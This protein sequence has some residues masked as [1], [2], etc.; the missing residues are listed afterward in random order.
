MKLLVRSQFLLFFIIPFVGYGQSKPQLSKA[1]H[2]SQYERAGY[3]HMIIDKQNIY[4]VVF[5]E[6]PDLR[7]PTYIYYSKSLDEGK[8]WSKPLNL[9][10]DGSGNGSGHPRLIL[11]KDGTLYAIW[12]RYGITGSAY[13]IREVG[14]DGRGGN[15]QGT[16]FAKTLYQGVWSSAFQ[17]SDAQGSQFSWFPTLHPNGKV[18]L[19]WSEVSPE[20]LKNNWLM[21]YYADWIRVASIGRT[22]VAERNTYSPY[23][24]ANYAGGPPKQMGAFNLDG[25]VAKDGALRLIFER[26]D[27]KKRCMWYFD[28]KK[29]EI[30]YT[31]PLYKEGN[32]FQNPARLLYDEKGLDHIIFKP[33]SSVLPSEQI[34]DIIPALKEK[35]VLAEISKKGVEIAGIQAG[36]GDGGKMAIAIQLGELVSATETIGIFY[37]SGKW[38]YMGITKNAAKQKFIYKEFTSLNT[39]SYLSTLTL[40]NSVHTSIAY[41]KFGKPQMVMTLSG[42][43]MA[44]GYRV[45][46]PS[47][48]FVKLN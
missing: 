38:N 14:L 30:V 33:Q 35:N 15:V 16:I 9:S 36:Q 48:D 19:I 47:L 12:K 44:G 41:D 17:I 22:G 31:Y 28:G 39:R 6:S 25:Y 11:D 26:I 18:L 29:Y 20:S 23:G 21:W 1:Q 4:H 43:A 27:D 5:Q 37:E 34:W 8:T 10:D 42:D 2:I 24:P 13:P 46:S 32:T 3:S 45:N 40:Y 7:K